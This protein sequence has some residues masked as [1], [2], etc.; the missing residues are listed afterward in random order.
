MTATPFTKLLVANRG[1]VAVRVMRTA[2]A[3][4]YRTVAIFSD[5]D[6][7][8]VHV[9][10]ADEAI[11][12]GGTSP[13]ES[14]LD[15]A[16]VIAAARRCGA[17]A[18]HPGYGFLAENA[19]FAQACREA[20]LTFVGPSPEAIVSMGDKAEAKRLMRAAGIPCIPGYQGSDQSEDRLF[21]E[22]QAIGWPVMIKAVAGGGGRGMRLVGSADEFA[23]ALASARSEAVSAFGNGD[24]LLE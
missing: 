6:A 13:A 23:P 5:A 17:D 24:M 16:K 11:G 4:G 12:I 15:I 3:M 22:G 18:V 9:A 14:Y 19:S 7:G 20:G 1:E 8:A 2:R 10:A 21:A